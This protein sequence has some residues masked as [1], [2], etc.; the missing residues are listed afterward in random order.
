MKPAALKLFLLFLLA[1]S[2]NCFALGLNPKPRTFYITL[3]LNSEKK[4]KVAVAPLKYN[5]HLAYSFVLDDGYRSAYLTAFPLLN[6]GKISP[7]FPDEWKNDQGG[8]GTYSDGLYFSD[9]CSQNIPFKLSLAI[10]A[11]SIS[12]SPENRG[13]LSWKEVREMYNA[14]WDVINH[15]YH[16]A[17]KPGTDFQKEVIQN[18]KA[19]KDSLNFVMSQFAVPGGE[20]EPGYE[21][22]YEKYAFQ[23]GSFAISSYKGIG[24]AIRV[25]KLLNLENLIY[26]RNFIQSKN[27]A[28]DFSLVEKQLSRLDSIMKLPEPIWYNEFTH[29]VGNSNLWSLSAV[30]PEFKKYMVSISDKYGSKGSDSI[31]MAP[32][33]EV[34]E[35]LWLR[36]KIEISSEQKGKE[37]VIRIDLPEIPESFRYFEISLALENT[38]QFTA[39]TTPPSLKIKHDGK[40]S[41]Q[42]LNI[43]FEK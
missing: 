13:H 16:H 40:T 31:W 24:P 35:Y 37:L 8:D 33:Q 15:G 9:G 39:K 12:D 32:F 30:F 17:T 5:K 6:G 4:A 14:G 10:N 34:Y 2:S 1:F 20:S 23:N 42:L 28:P 43:S 22:E 21:H 41:H 18:I 36:D 29:G 38:G 25:G 19:V 27:E 11:G 7:P 3:K 26:E